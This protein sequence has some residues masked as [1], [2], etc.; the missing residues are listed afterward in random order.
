MGKINFTLFKDILK[1]KGL[2]G[3]TSYSQGRVY[4]LW[5]IIAYYI[6]LGLV[7]FKSMRPD[8]QINVDMLKTVIESLQWALAL[9]AGYV[10]GTK[11]LDAIKVV[12]GKGSSTPYEPPAAA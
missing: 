9:F 2:D 8:V 6:T 11:G 1:E 5:S 10:F 4:L 3:A 7:T 12:M